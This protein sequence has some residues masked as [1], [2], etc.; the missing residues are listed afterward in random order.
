MDYGIFSWLWVQLALFDVVGKQLVLL[1]LLLLVLPFGLGILFLCWC[2]K[3]KFH[4]FKDV[5]HPPHQ[6]SIK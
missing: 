1:V 2:Y 6:R 5:A 3:E 4:S